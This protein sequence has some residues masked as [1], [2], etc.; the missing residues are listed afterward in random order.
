MDVTLV[1]V[2]SPRGEMRVPR[3]LMKMLNMRLMVRLWE[4]W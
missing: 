2:R 3:L 4:L 1:T